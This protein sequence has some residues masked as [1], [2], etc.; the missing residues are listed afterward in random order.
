[1]AVDSSGNLTADQ[2]GRSVDVTGR[3]RDR[4]RKLGQRA[5][6]A[7][8]EAIA[9][10]CDQLRQHQAEV[11]IIAGYAVPLPAMN[12]IRREAWGQG[13]DCGW[14]SAVTAMSELPDAKDA[15]S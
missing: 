3:V 7:H 4:V 12:L 14:D 15:G 2:D 10:T 11:T 6:Q 8:T 13:F 5:S 9:Y 1:M